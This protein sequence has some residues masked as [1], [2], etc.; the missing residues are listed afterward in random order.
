[1][2]GGVVV[3]W[4]EQGGVKCVHSGLGTERE[5]EKTGDG[6]CGRDITRLR[7]LW[8]AEVAYTGRRIM[9]C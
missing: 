4:I 3:W 1:M 5:V 2:Y 7:L 6:R 9:M 8:C